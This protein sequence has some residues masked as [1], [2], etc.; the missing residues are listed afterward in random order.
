MTQECKSNIN[1]LRGWLWG[2][3]DRWTLTSIQCFRWN[4]MAYA[5]LVFPSF[6]FYNLWVLLRFIYGFDYLQSPEPLDFPTVEERTAC[7][8]SMCAI[9][10]WL[11][12]WLPPWKIMLDSRF[13]PSL[14][15]FCPCVISKIW[16]GGWGWRRG[17]Y[18]LGWVQLFC[19]IS[20]GINT[21]HPG[22]SYKISTF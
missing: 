19:V 21:Q 9:H 4:S 8:S 17:R 6:T 16:G 15:G 12:L 7:N 20:I 18:F 3:C 2:L 11:Y 13:C 1:G 5:V 10:M 14:R 22:H